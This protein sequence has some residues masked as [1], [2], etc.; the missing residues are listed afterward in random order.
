MRLTAA[1]IAAPTRER[2]SRI[3]S[4]LS[5]WVPADEDNAVTVLFW[6]KGAGSPNVTALQGLLAEQSLSTGVVAAAIA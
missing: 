2:L 1:T 6:R 3:A 5:W 4:A